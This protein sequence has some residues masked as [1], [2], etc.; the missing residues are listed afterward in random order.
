[1][2]FEYPCDGLLVG[3]AVTI[4]EIIPR[5]SAQERPDISQLHTVQQ[6]TPRYSAKSVHAA[7]LNLITLALVGSLHISV[8]LLYSVSQWREIGAG[9]PPPPYTS[10]DFLG[11]SHYLV[12]Y[13]KV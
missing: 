4:M 11:T 7:D 9:K 5:T 12:K 6:G 10:G 13:A 2:R 8:L 1:M 3:P